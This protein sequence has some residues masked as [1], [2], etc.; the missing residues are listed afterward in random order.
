MQLIAKNL[1]HCTRIVFNF[2]PFTKLFL[3][4]FFLYSSI[5][6]KRKGWKRWPSFHLSSC[7]RQWWRFDLFL[8]LF[9]PRSLRLPPPLYHQS[10]KRRKKVDLFDKF[11]ILWNN[12]INF[13]MLYLILNA[14][15]CI[16]AW[17]AEIVTL[18]EM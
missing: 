5:D 18:G 16:W 13:L 10:R 14:Y 12:I 6:W 4:F 1:C 3:S 7:R 15:M 2:L 11:I 17:Y 9:S 8:K